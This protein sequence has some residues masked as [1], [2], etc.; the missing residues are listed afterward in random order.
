MGLPAGA[1]REVVFR[2]IT[3]GRT[4]ELSQAMS[5]SP[6]RR[7]G[8][9][10]AKRQW[11]SAESAAAYRA[12][13]SPATSARYQQENAILTAWIADLDQGSLILDVPCGAGRFTQLIVDCGFD[14]LGADFSGAMAAE[15]R[16][17]TSSPRVKGFLS[18]DAQHLP[19]DDN[20]V[21]CVVLWRL[22]H[23]IGDARIRQEILREA[24]RV[25]RSRVLLSFHHPVSFTGMRLLLR[26]KLFGAPSKR[27]R[28]SHWRL[29]REARNCGLRMAATKSFWK[30]VSIN[31]FACLV[32]SADACATGRP[33]LTA[34]P[35]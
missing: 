17:G 5:N 21:D 9:Y 20:S 2:C 14:Y 24:A 32:K 1:A 19:L 10:P 7:P 35:G 29:E 34:P 30:Y 25:T 3:G 11:Q 12:A 22:L 16:R 27:H 4:L 15:A 8:D 6:D 23:H 26:Q 33:S 13:R 18:A 28:V 31:W